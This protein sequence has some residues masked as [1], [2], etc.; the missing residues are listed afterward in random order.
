VL[1]DRRGR[2]VYANPAA[3]ELMSAGAPLRNDHGKLG[4]RGEVV[5]GH[6]QIAI[7][8]A[9]EGDVPLGRRGIAIPGARPDGTPFVVHVM[10]LHDRTTRVGLPG[11]S[12]AAV[13][14]AERDDDP[15]LVIDAATLIYSLTPAEARVFEL[16]IAGHSSA[17]MAQLLAVAPSTLKYHTL[18]LYDKTGQHRRADLVRLAGKLRPAG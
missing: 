16:I 15:Q 3:T 13:F 5:P 12:I 1:V 11:E 7:D 14:V 18:Q 8:A 17:E 2:I 10:P 6:L 9:A 4:L